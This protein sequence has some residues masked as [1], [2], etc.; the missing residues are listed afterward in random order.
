MHT[1]LNCVLRMHVYLCLVS[2]TRGCECAW[3]G[4][5]CGARGHTNVDRATR[6]RRRTNV[7]PVA[8]E[9]DTRGHTKETD[10]RTDGRTWHTMNLMQ[11]HHENDDGRMMASR[12]TP[13]VMRRMRPENHFL[14]KA[15][16]RC[17][18]QWV[19]SGSVSVVLP[20][21]EGKPRRWLLLGVPQLSRALFVPLHRVQNL[22]RFLLAAV[23]SANP[24]PQ[25]G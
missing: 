16:P 19:K 4:R 25:T 17:L 23:D 21:P 3:F 6:K 13:D 2:I 14:Y 12:G 7:A 18:L 10:G 1:K 9:C 11:M 20:L 8:H 24:A 22:D 5:M 15:L